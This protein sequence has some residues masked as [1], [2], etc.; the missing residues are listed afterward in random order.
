VQRTLTAGA[1]PQTGG[2]SELFIN[3][4]KKMKKDGILQYVAHFD[5]LLAW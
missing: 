5:G 2:G 4:R 3:T 1:T